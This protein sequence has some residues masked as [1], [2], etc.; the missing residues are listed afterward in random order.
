MWCAARACGSTIRTGRAYLDVYNNV[1]SVGHCHPHVVAAL[2]RQA[3]M[4]NTHTRYLHESVLDYAERL[5]GYFPPA[6]GHV[7][8]TCTGSEANDLALRVAEG[9]HRR[10]RRDRHAKSPI[11]ASPAPIAEMSPSLG[12]G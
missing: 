1:A 10:H 2:S 8:F 7:M 12:A 6:L 3:A 5:L 9:A 4:L 11:T